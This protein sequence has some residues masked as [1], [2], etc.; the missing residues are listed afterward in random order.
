[1]QETK[2]AEA[3]LKVDNGVVISGDPAQW[4]CAECGLGD[5]LWLNLS[6]GHIGCGRQQEGGQ[7]GHSHALKHFKDSGELYPLAVK[8]GTIT[9]DGKGDVYSY[10]A[11]EDDMVKNPFLAEHLARWVSRTQPIC[12]CAYISFMF[13]VHAGHQHELPQ[14]DGEING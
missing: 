8:L 3:L 10:A 7:E 12:F 14:Q 1:M 2:Y 4:K 5:N 6:D 11:D 13:R 9:Q